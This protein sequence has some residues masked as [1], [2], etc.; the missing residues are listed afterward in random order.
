VDAAI[1]VLADHDMERRWT[2]ENFTELRQ[3][4]GMDTV[5]SEYVRLYGDLGVGVG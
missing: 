3:F 2:D 5:A 1:A 4:C